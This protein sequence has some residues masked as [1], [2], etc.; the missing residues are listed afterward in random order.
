MFEMPDFTAICLTSVLGLMGAIQDSSCWCA[1][2]RHHCTWNIRDITLGSLQDLPS[3][4]LQDL[5]N[6]GHHQAHIG[7]MDICGTKIGD[8][9]N[10]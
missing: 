6:M 10:R 1:G 4:D 2:G 8:S 5:P 3:R 9:C 7:I